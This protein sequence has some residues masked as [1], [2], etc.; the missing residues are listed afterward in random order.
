MYSDRK[1]K[2]SQG[3]KRGDKFKPRPGYTGCIICQA[4]DCHSSR[5]TEEEKA[6]SKAR[7]FAARKAE[8]RHIWRMRTVPD[9]NQGT[10]GRRMI[11]ERK[12]GRRIQTRPRK[13]ATQIL[14]QTAI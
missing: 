7:Y 10:C 13:A 8:G 6:E 1:M 2:F 3:N 4:P 9:R 5:H 12:Q 14:T 11:I